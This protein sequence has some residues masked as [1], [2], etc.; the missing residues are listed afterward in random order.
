MITELKATNAAATN[1]HGTDSI[2]TGMTPGGVIVYG[3]YHDDSKFWSAACTEEYPQEY[4]LAIDAAGI[5]NEMSD[6]EK[7]VCINNYLCAITEYGYAETQD[8][9]LIP[10]GVIGLDIF[11]Y[12]KGVCNAYADAFQTMTSMVGI[13]CYV[14]RS[15]SLN[16][17]WN[18]VIIDGI[19]YFVD[20]TWNDSLNCNY[21]LMSTTLWDDHI[22]RDIEIVINE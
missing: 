21:Y 1:E 6:Y 2:P 20:V 19:S 22:A 8:S 16:H 9:R 17:A 4:L 14:I 13:P 11:Q 15:E 10:Y 7:C 18:G 12:G 5:T 3:Y